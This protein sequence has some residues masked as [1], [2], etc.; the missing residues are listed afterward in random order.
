MRGHLL[1]PNLLKNHSQASGL[2][3]SPTAFINIYMMQASPLIFTMILCSPE[4]IILR[5]GRSGE[6]GISLSS[7]INFCMTDGVV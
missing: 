6:A 5:D 7:D 2:R 3:H 1:F 4:P